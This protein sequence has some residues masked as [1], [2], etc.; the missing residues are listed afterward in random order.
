M[1]YVEAGGIHISNRDLHLELTITYL[2][3]DSKET[4]SD[5]LLDRRDLSGI[6]R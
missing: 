2:Q 5:C 4:G 6:E 3:G 1:M